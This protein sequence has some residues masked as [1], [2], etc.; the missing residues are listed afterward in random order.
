MAWK[1]G[2][3]IRLYENEISNKRKRKNK[4]LNSQQNCFGFL[5]NIICQRQKEL[6]C[7]RVAVG[8]YRVRINES[9]IICGILVLAVE[10][11]H[12]VLRGLGLDSAPRE[13]KPCTARRGRV[14][15]RPKST[16]PVFTSALV[17]VAGKGANAAKFSLTSAPSLLLTLYSRVVVDKYAALSSPACPGIYRGVGRGGEVGRWGGGGGGSER[18]RIITHTQNNPESRRAHIR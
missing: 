3:H 9:W 4:K 7:Q 1:G 8:L 5:N 10:H 15:Q 12:R 16:A 6:V 2:S 13:A 18:G 14:L 17:S 11:A